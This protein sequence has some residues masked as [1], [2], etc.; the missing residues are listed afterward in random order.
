MVNTSAKFDEE[1]HYGLVVIVFTSLFSYMYIVTL[2]F[3]F[4]NQKGSS[5]HHG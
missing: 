3:D 1:I 4:Q 2:T 5:T